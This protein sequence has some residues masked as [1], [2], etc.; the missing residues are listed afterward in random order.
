MNT[1]THPHLLFFVC[2]F[3]TNNND[4][5]LGIY[6]PPFFFICLAPYKEDN[7]KH[8]AHCCPFF[9][10]LSH[11][12]KDDDK[13]SSS[14]FFNF[15]VTFCLQ[16]TKMTRSLVLFIILFSFY[17]YPLAK[18]MTM[19]TQ[20]VIIFFL[21]SFVSHYKKD[22]DECSLSSLTHHPKL[23]D[24]LNYEFK[25]ENSR[26]I[27]SWGTLPDSQHFGGRRVC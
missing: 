26:R 13:H 25:C 14:L 11:Y 15:F 10:C 20:L 8:L 17:V 27:K 6:C 23:L 9:Y 18:K 3:T 7:D 4:N 16:Q 24:R 21:L 19:N 5:E 1:F 2:F 22:D 12:W